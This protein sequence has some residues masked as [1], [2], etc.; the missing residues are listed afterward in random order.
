M[1]EVDVDTEE[2]V[3]FAVFETLDLVDTERA[4]FNLVGHAGEDE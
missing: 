3:V 4:L 1:D 2:G